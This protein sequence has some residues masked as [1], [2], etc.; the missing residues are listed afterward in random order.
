MPEKKKKSDEPQ[1]KYHVYWLDTAADM[2]LSDS[3]DT[4]EDVVAKISTLDTEDIKVCHG[5]DI[6]FSG[7]ELAKRVKVGGKVYTVN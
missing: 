3:F 6:A 5:K 2:L 4:M 7:V 1:D